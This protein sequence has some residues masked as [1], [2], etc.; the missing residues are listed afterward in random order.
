MENSVLKLTLSCKWYDMIESGT[1]KEEY[2]EI[3]P[4]WIGRICRKKGKRLTKEECSTL[5][6]II[7]T[8]PLSFLAAIIKEGVTFHNYRMITFY[9]GVPYFSDNAKHMTWS[10]ESTGIGIGDTNWGAP[11][12]EHVIKLKLGGR[13]S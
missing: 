5:C 6:D 1:K 2:R 12:Y 3:K 10:I 7:K 4:Y 11:K 8:N 13:I 9:R